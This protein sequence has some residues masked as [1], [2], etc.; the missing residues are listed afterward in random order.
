M[1]NILSAYCYTIKYLQCAIRLVEKDS[2]SNSWCWKKAGK[3]ISIAISGIIRFDRS[4]CWILWL[5]WGVNSA[6]H[7][8]G[9]LK[10]GWRKEAIP[11]DLIWA[12]PY[13]GSSRSRTEFNHKHP[14]KMDQPK[15]LGT[16]FIDKST[17]AVDLYPVPRYG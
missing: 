5:F 10:G 1:Q 8:R 15:H 13:P 14:S 16:Y 4:V 12:F 2:S 3:I 11:W 6:L 7:F 9:G 17:S